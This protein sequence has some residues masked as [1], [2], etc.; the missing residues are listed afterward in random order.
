MIL[1]LL[2]YTLIGFGAQIIDGSLGM[3]YG[4]SS[5]T[6]LLSFGVLPAIA[7]A[8]VHTAEVFTTGVSGFSHFKMGNINKT[9][10]LRL[11]LPGIIGG[12]VGAYILTTIPVNIIKPLISLYLLIMGMLIIVKALRKMPHTDREPRPILLAL[13]GGFFDAIGGGG[14]GPIVTTTLIARG[15]N[16]RLTIGSVNAS[17]FFVTLAESIAFF[18]ILGSTILENWLIIVGLLLGGVIA[19]PLAA[20]MVKRIP[21]RALMFIVGGLISALSL[22]TIILVFIG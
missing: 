22:R 11:I 1:T 17:E 4:V 19:A 18:A 15:H 3:A 12:V 16:P 21:S 5:N 14:W 13:I 8:C 20:W 10:F 6:F 9:L 2:M 7:S